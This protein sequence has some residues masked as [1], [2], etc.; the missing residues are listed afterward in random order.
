MTD[1]AK[2]EKIEDHE[3]SKF[4]S[5]VRVPNLGKYTAVSIK[6]VPQKRERLR[7]NADWY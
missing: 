6:V 3:G 5:F 4:D 7:D 2:S 1:C